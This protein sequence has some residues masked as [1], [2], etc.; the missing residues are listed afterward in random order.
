MLYLILAKDGTDEGAPARRK[1]V[2]EQHLK[3]V[4]S[5]VASG[6][7]KLGGAL[8]NDLGEMTG[9]ALLVEAASEAEVRDFL[10]NDI[11]FKGGVWQ[12][13]KIYP[14]KRAVGVSL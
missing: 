2:R 7:V 12:T 8:L 1:K 3:E 11:Y 5:A 10:E 14:F 4:E 9:S 6:V 13:F